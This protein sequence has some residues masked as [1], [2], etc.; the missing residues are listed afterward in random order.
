[1]DSN[2]WIGLAH[3][4][5]FANNALLGDGSGAFVP[6]V[7]LAQNAEELSTLA[8]TLL[9]HHQFEVVEVEDIEL[10]STRMKKHSVEHELLLVVET[11]SED[12]RVQ[13]GAFQVYRD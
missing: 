11:L 8:A 9:Y 1:M 2:V 6:V 13:V 10:L 7:G 3:V 4:R 12:N 5:P